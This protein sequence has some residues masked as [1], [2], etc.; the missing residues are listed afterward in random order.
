MR[1]NRETRTSTWLRRS[2]NSVIGGIR[3]TIADPASGARVRVVVERFAA[4][5][6]WVARISGPGRL[7]TT[8]DACRAHQGNG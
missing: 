6:T 2:A 8:A 7:M 3:S 4:V 1:N 5:M